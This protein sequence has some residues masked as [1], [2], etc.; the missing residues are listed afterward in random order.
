MFCRACR[1]RVGRSSLR[2]R[3]ARYPGTRWPTASRPLPGGSQD[4]DCPSPAG[5]AAPSA[6]TRPPRAGRRAGVRS[7]AARTTRVRRCS[8]RLRVPHSR[9]RGPGGVRHRRPARIRRRAGRH[10]RPRR[11]AAVSTCQGR[12]A[13]S[14]TARAPFHGTCV[15]PEWSPTCRCSWSLRS[16]PALCR[17]AAAGSR[18]RGTIT[19]TASPVGRVPGS[20][21]TSVP[22]RSRELATA[23]WPAVGASVIR[24]RVPPR[25]RRR[26][27][28]S[29]RARDRRFRSR[30]GC[31]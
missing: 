9:R 17:V 7:P 5:S 14:T 19:L 22:P 18:P 6:P 2:D 11:A 12:P 24:R 8:A 28:T 31:R 3:R 27:C 23:H 16:S 20:R 13:G 30:P 4:Q 21:P 1:R 10:F 26:A 29:A 25:R 15:A